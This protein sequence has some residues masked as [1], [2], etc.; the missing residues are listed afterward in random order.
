MVAR[1]HNAVQHP[2]RTD[3]GDVPLCYVAQDGR[4]FRVPRDRERYRG[5]QFT[6]PPPPS[7]LFIAISIT[8]IQVLSR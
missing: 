4:V 1:I 8:L 2:Q 3:S 5:V 7:N 6:P